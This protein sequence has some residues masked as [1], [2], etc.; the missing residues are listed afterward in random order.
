ME[1]GAEVMLRFQESSFQ[2]LEMILTRTLTVISP[3][4]GQKSNVP[5]C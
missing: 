3:C 4:S 5:F 2:F 1:G